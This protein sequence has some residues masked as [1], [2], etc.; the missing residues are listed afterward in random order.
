MSRRLPYGGETDK[1][2]GGS[3]GE[4]YDERGLF[5]AARKAVL[6]RT[7]QFSGAGDANPETWTQDPENLRG[8]VKM[9]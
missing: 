3:A 8:S 6:Y 2:V 7:R 4:S 5:M 1:P 9:Q